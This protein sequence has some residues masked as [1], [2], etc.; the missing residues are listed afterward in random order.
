MQIKSHWIEEIRHTQTSNLS[1]GT[2]TPRFV[3]THYTTGW[4]GEGS[5]NWLQGKAGGHPESEVS[6]HVVIDVDGT[7]WQIAPFN[8]RAWHAGPSRFGSVTDLNSHSIGLEFVNPGWLKPNGPGKWLDYY[9][10]PKTT[11]ELEARGGFLEAPHPIVGSGSFAW[12]L[13]PPA[14]IKTGLAIVA[15]IVATYDIVAIVTHEEIDTRGWKT[16]PG[17]AFPQHSFKD[18]LG[19]GGDP[20]PPPRYVVAATRLNL[21]GG[22]AGTAEKVEPPGT[23]PRGTEVQSLRV[24]GTWHFVEVTAVPTPAPGLEIGLRGWVHG[25]Y[26]DLVLTA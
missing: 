2:I 21:R 4:S 25:D 16:D 15:A 18:L 9:K 23:L 1:P 11:E 20:A 12:P 8:R 14:Q 3:V 19:Q 24:E 10:T 6:A 26:L 22:P 5:R 7:A 13:F 17:P